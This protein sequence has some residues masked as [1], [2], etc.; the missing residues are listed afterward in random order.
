MEINFCLQFELSIGCLKGRTGVISIQ[1]HP[2]AVIDMSE[3]EEE[4]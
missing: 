3:E 1:V 4:E 2:K